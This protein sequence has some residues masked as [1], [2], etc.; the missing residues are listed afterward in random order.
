MRFP[1]DEFECYRRSRLWMQLPA[2]YV[3]EWFFDKHPAA[4]L[5]RI[6]SNLSQLSNELG[7]ESMPFT[8]SY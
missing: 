3:R 1:Q 8:L 4:S 2:A 5:G 7:R 6:W